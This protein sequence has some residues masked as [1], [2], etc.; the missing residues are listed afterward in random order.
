MTDIRNA[1][2]VELLAV[3]FFTRWH[4]DHVTHLAVTQNIVIDVFLK[5][6]TIEQLEAARARGLELLDVNRDVARIAQ[7]ICASLASI[8]E[9]EHYALLPLEWGRA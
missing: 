2:F 6:T 9:N 3:Q 7:V 4:L 8:E 1:G 5:G